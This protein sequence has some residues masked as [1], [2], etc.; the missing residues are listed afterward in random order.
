MSVI[1]TG[2]LQRKSLILIIFTRIFT[3]IS[4]DEQTKKNQAEIKISNT[5]NHTAVVTEYIVSVFP[6][7]RGVIT[8]KS[9]RKKCL[10]II[11]GWKFF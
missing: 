4:C 9:Y 6:A 3:Y 10:K 1:R 7:I 5:E 2:L 8:G 11:F